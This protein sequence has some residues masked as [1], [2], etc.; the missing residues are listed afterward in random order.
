MPT[1]P[2]NDLRDPSARQRPGAGL[3]RARRVDSGQ[4][5]ALQEL[6]P[7][8]VASPTQLFTDGARRDSYTNL[9]AHAGDMCVPRTRIRRAGAIIDYW[10]GAPASSVT[11][12]IHASGGAEVARVT[13]TNHRGINRVVW[14]L[15]ATELLPPGAPAPPAAGGAGG[16]PRRP[17]PRGRGGF[18]GTA[19]RSRRVYRALDG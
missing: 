7:A 18:A 17:R 5:D 15:R 11:L 3:A 16:G 2:F 19:R 14:N 9:K 8:V 13:A 10:L 4:I 6:T 12:S 1:L